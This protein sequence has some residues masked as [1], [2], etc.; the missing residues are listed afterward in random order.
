MGVE[1]HSLYLGYSKNF[2]SSWRDC[3]CVGV[4]TH[5]YWDNKMMFP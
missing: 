4:L 1:K 5:F 2:V 3:V